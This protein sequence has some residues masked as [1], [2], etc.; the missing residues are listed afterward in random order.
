M[1]ALG[2]RLAPV[3]DVQAHAPDGLNEP[4]VLQDL[5]GL[6]ERVAGDLVLLLHLDGGGDAPTWGNRPVLN[7]PP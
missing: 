4:F 1:S 2:G 3:N 6:A 5:R 7:L